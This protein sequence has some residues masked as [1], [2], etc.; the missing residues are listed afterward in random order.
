MSTKR[1]THSAQFKAM[2]ALEALKEQATLNKIA[3]RHG[4]LPAQVSQLETQLA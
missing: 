2:V 1:R 4:V 3:N